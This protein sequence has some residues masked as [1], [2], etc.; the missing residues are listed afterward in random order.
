MNPVSPVNVTH[1]LVEERVVEPHPQLVE[2]QRVPRTVRE[3]KSEHS[4]EKSAVE[5]AE[6]DAAKNVGRKYLICEV[7]AISECKPVTTTVRTQPKESTKMSIE[8]VLRGIPN[9]GERW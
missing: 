1:I 8:D 5:Q 3:I 7:V 2:S 9:P 6:H 4:S